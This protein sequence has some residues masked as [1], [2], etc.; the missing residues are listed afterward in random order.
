[1]LAVLELRFS[2]VLEVGSA[3]S[4]SQMLWR[5]YSGA[6]SQSVEYPMWSLIPLLPKGRISRACDVSDAVSYQARG[7]VL[8][9]ASALLS[10]LMLVFLF[11]LVVRDCSASLRSSKELVALYVV[12]VL[13]FPREE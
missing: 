8:D 10:F 1:M 11:I 9:R 2:K 3:A 4:Q 6:G 12:V 5:L 7:L 13:M